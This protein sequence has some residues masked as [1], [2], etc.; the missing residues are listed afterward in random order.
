MGGGATIVIIIC[1]YCKPPKVL[2]WKCHK[3]DEPLRPLPMMISGVCDKCSRVYP[4][5]EGG[6]THGICLEHEKQEKKWG[7]AALSPEEMAKVREVEQ[8]LEAMSIS[9]PNPACGSKQITSTNTSHRCLDCG[10]RF[11]YKSQESAK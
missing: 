11:P 9:C 3:C 10:T 1:S 4:L 2:G 5:K 7:N 8:K 6:T